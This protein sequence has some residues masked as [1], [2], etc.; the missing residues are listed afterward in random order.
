MIKREDKN[1]QW[2]VM[3]DTRSGKEFP[4][5]YRHTSKEK[6]EIEAERLAKKFNAKFTVFESYLKID[7][8]V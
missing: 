6:A 8:R 7:G 1:K 5:T 4:V 2:L 3:R